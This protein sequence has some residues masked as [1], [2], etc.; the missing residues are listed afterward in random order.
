MNRDRD[1]ESKD[2][3]TGEACRDELWQAPH[4]TMCDIFLYSALGN[5]CT[6]SSIVIVVDLDHLRC[7]PPLIGTVYKYSHVVTVLTS[8][9]WFFIP[10]SDTNVSWFSQTIDVNYLSEIWHFCVVVYFSLK[11]TGVFMTHWFKRPLVSV[12]GGRGSV[13]SIIVTTFLILWGRFV[14]H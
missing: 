8:R 12:L 11:I 9:H 3:Y 5:R 4:N 2:Y 10:S 13:G 7:F 1:T 14:R 6:I